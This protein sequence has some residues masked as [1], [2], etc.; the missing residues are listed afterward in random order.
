VAARL[1]LE[2]GS[3]SAGQ[4]KGEPTV[5]GQP[6]AASVSPKVGDGGSGPVG[7]SRLGG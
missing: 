5:L 4:P 7:P 6:V 3:S 2:R 1:L